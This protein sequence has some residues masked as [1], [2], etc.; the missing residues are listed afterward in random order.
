MEEVLERLNS[1]DRK[2]IERALEI[3][4]LY[5]AR[6]IQ[7]ALQGLGYSVRVPDIHAWHRDRGIKK[8][9]C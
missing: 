1:G 5:P 7:A 9:T 6:N 3:P 8:A 4:D 2:T